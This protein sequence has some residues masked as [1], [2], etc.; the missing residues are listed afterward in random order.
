MCVCVCVC[1][2]AHS[3]SYVQLIVT[4]RTVARQVPLSIGFSRQEYWSEQPFPSHFLTQ[5]WNPCLLCLLHWLVDS[6][7]LSYLISPKWANVEREQLKDYC[8]R[9]E[10]KDG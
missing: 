3:F 10:R 7:P 6:L 9:L 1:V 5:G 4:P 2:C 8:N